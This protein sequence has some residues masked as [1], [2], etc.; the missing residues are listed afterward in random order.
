MSNR[1]HSK[2]LR[3]TVTAPA[4]V[5]SLRSLRETGPA[6]VLEDG[7]TVRVRVVGWDSPQEVTDDGRTTYLEQFERGGLLPGDGTVLAEMEHGGQII[8]RLSGTDVAEDG[9]YADVRVADTAT[10]RDTL[11]LIDEGL[12]SV[13]AEF[14]DTPTTAA[15]GELVTRSSARL[16][17][18]AFT[19]VPQHQTAA[20]LGRRSHPQETPPM[21]DD[22]NTAE[23]TLEDAA[24]DTTPEIET[25]QRSAPARRP[26]PSL[27]TATDVTEVQTRFRSFGEFVH[28]AATGQIPKAERERYYRALSSATTSDTAGLVRT[29]WLNDVIDLI[30]PSMPTVAAFSQAPLP[31][32]GFTVSQPTVTTRPTVAA[33]AAQGDAISSQKA[34]IGT[35]SWTVGTYAGGQGMSMQAILRTEPDYLTEVMRL[36]VV[37]LA[38]EIEEAVV[39][40]VL[41]AADDVHTAVELSNTAV[42]YQDAFVDAA[43][44]ILGSAG[45]QRL[46]DVA[47]LNVP[48]WVLLA[49]AKDTTGRPLFPGLSPTNPQGTLEL[50]STTGELRSLRYYVSPKM[51]TANAKAVVGVAEAFRTMLGPI[52]T[53]QN[54]VPETLT[55]EHAV[56]QFAAFGKV[57]ARGLALIQNAS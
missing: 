15:D 5:V 27:R 9:L 37:E 34:V 10:G 16:T 51:A 26:S 22:E 24:P 11:A 45:I 38:L 57:D 32:K 52:Q 25:V 41:A 46:P 55:Q 44:L 54:D 29:Q 48:M 49:K 42:D 40:A 12:L 6:T 43:A 21:E 20:V 39:A 2:H 56:F 8:G 13:S 28:A 35:T 31:D 14:E 30:R 3:S 19:H 50:T 33:Q 7:R 36:H 17:R 47:V 53:M 1:R 23:Q 18:L 4:P